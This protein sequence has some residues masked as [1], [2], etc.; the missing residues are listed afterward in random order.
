MRSI[1]QRSSSLAGGSKA[2]RGSPSTNASGRPWTPPS[3]AVWRPARR[4]VILF[5]VLCRRP[6]LLVLRAYVG[7]EHI[8]EIARQ[9]RHRD[10]L[11]H[12][13]EILQT[14]RRGHAG[15]ELHLQEAR[16]RDHTKAASGG[17][18]SRPR[19]EAHGLGLAVTRVI[20]R[21]PEIDLDT[22]DR[23]ADGS[24][25]GAEVDIAPP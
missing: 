21:N 19:G 3:L 16:Q 4:S 25:A 8:S 15:G 24:S 14:V 23:V 12:V 20:P 7:V 5:R 9:L 18:R 10:Q 11:E 1:S 22:V 17:G 2:S 13:G 6:E